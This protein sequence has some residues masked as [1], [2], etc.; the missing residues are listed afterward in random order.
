MKIYYGNN[1]N[2]DSIKLLDNII[3]ELLKEK[4]NYEYA[5]DKFLDLYKDTTEKFYTI[6][7]L[8]LNWMGDISIQYIYIVF[9][10]EEIQCMYDKHIVDKLSIMGIGEALSEDYR[11]N[12][13]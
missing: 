9:N 3:I 12:N 5:V 10:D 11:L 7:P 2:K 13:E 4:N 8:I 1:P 6:N